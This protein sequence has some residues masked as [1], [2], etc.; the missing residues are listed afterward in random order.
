MHVFNLTLARPALQSVAPTL[1]ALIR[2]VES[3]WAAL[4]DLDRADKMVRLAVSLEPVLHDG[5][6]SLPERQEAINQVQAPMIAAVIL[7]C[8]A[9]GTSSDERS[10]FQ[11]AKEQ[12]HPLYSAAERIRKARNSAIGHWGAGGED[13]IHPWT[14]HALRMHIDEEGGWLEYE[15]NMAAFS[16]A[17]IADLQALIPAAKEWLEAKKTALSDTLVDRLVLVDEKLG[18]LYQ[19][20]PYYDSQVYGK[21]S[22]VQ[23]GVDENGLLTAV[24]FTQGI[25]PSKRDQTTGF[26]HLVAGEWRSYTKLR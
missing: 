3:A 9:T 18:R 22:V 11:F 19:S 23:K 14:K 6:L 8:R 26:E 17:S 25:L 4:F 2:Q 15:A 16:S 7:Y 12:N 20:V 5:E 13:V 10:V 21:G 24:S 1:Y